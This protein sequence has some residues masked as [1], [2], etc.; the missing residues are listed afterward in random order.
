ML[1]ITGKLKNPNI[2]EIEI[3]NPFIKI[4]PHL[5]P[6]GIIEV[7]AE[8]CLRKEYLLADQLSYRYSTIAVFSLPIT[9]NQLQYLK[10]ENDMYTAIIKSTE[11]VLISYLQSTN[12]NIQ[13]TQI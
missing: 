11:V 5:L 3:T 13:I 1:Q 8:I 6:M 4:C 10:N 9:K 7:D 2:P 12:P